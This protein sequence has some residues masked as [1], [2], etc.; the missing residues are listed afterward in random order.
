[1]TS[2]KLGPG[3]SVFYGL[4]ADGTHT[5]PAAV[6]IAYRTNFESMCLVTDAITGLGLADGRYNLG[7]Q[8]I[9][10]MQNPQLGSKSCESNSAP[11]PTTSFRSGTRWP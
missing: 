11:I 4:I 8:P 10:V 3:R 6:R 5:H 9:E 7:E 1:M 2:R